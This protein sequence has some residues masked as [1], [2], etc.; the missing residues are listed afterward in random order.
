VF[1]T[2][3]DKS[4]DKDNVRTI[5]ARVVDRANERRAGRG[6]ASL[7]RVVPHTLRR[8]DISLMLEAGAPLTT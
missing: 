1:A 6:Q 4:R 8:T 7:P 5:R 2:A 3:S